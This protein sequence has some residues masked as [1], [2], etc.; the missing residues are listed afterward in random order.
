[1]KKFFHSR[2]QVLC[3]FC[4]SPRHIHRKRHIG[5]I[6]FAGSALG[7]AA[8]TAAVF[9]G[10]DGR[11]LLIFGAFVV[12]AE[13]FVQMRWRVSIP[14]PHCGFDPV[15]YSRKPEDAAEKVKIRLAARKNDPRALLGRPLS[16][17]VRRITPED[18]RHKGQNLSREV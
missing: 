7:A 16:I 8:I 1:M 5:V 15:L 11:G 18:R 4:R 12:A 9:G 10:F 17:P 6:D 14:C 13:I 2:V 3:A